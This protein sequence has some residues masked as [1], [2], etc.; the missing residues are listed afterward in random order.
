MAG[1]GTLLGWLESTRAS[2]KKQKQTGLVELN[3]GWLN[4]RLGERNRE[5]IQPEAGGRR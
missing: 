2:R 3:P 5:L 1:F 4:P